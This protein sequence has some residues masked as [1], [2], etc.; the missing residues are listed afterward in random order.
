MPIVDLTAGRVHY[1][2]AGQGIP[3]LLLHANPGDSLDFAAIVPALA[4]HYRVLALDWPGYG[5][6]PAPAPPES[7]SALYYY[8]VL[9][10]FIAVLKLPP[11]LLIGNSLG[12]NAAARLAIE[13]P[14]AVKGLVLV[15]PGGFTPHNLVSRSFCRFQGSRFA[16]PP[17]FFAQMYLKHRSPT[18]KE[19]LLRAAT[20]Q[21][22]P[23]RLAVNRAVWRSFIDPQH[24]L[25]QSASAIRAPTLLL[26]GKHDPVIPAKKDGRI[27]A[28]VI[29][30]ARLVV[31]L[32][33]HAPFAEIPEV[34][35]AE[36][37][38]FLA[39][40]SAT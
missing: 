31:P 29:P 8:S 2:E 26:F 13:Q 27:A 24:D 38:P 36:V 7:A 21:A 40:C 16:I 6:S 35:L 4:A 28:Q 19:M 25:R 10:E 12:G 39:R 34:F 15:S 22:T 32:S 5:Q 30:S 1:R 37:L 9:R 18:V 14:Q 20:G 11:A 33:G 17:K 23:E 3:L